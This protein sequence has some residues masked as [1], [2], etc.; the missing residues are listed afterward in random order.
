M[1][2]WDRRLLPAALALAAAGAAAQEPAPSPAG[3]GARIVLADP[4]RGFDRPAPGLTLDVS[5]SAAIAGP[6]SERDLSES[7]PSLD[8]RL[9]PADVD[10]YLASKDYEQLTDHYFRK[11]PV[12]AGKQFKKLGTAA[13]AALI[14]LGQDELLDELGERAA[15][16]TEKLPAGEAA[17]VGLGAQALEVGAQLGEV[18]ALAKPI[19]K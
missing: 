15:E 4:A 17:A 1:R 9:N 16:F 18:A 3:E 13:V 14:K 19:S 6:A 10:S 8:L 7:A 11:N 5:T 2:H 12:G